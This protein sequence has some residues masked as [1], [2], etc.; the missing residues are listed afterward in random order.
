MRFMSRRFLVFVLLTAL[1]L[2]SCSENTA[3]DKTTTGS[4][5]FRAQSSAYVRKGKDASTYV[6]ENRSFRFAEVLGD[7]G[8]YEAL[9][10][11]EETYHNERTLGMEGTDGEITIN[12]W[13]LKNGQQRDLAH[14]EHRYRVALLPRL[15]RHDLSG[16]SPR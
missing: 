11:L 9:L 4:S 12:A 6:T 8:N 16:F 5:E 15:N 1:A 7:T 3:H 13:T 14:P 2:I 10:L